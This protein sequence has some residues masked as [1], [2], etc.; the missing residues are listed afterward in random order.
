MSVE[1]NNEGYGNTP[2]KQFTPLS[3]KK[4]ITNFLIREGFAKDERGAQI[5][6]LFC[7]LLFFIASGIIFAFAMGRNTPIASQ[8]D[9][10]DCKENYNLAEFIDL[11]PIEFNEMKI[12]IESL[13]SC[14]K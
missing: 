12:Y 5:I 4:G 14:I 13:P 7:A 8:E 2:I 10:V 1:F 11:S 3:Q 9:F 6:L